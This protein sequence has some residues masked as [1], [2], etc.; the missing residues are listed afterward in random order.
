MYVHR[1]LLDYS[2]SYELRYDERYDYGDDYISYPRER[3]G[4]LCFFCGFRCSFNDV[5]CRCVGMDDAPSP[6]A[7]LRVIAAAALL[8]FACFS[9]AAA[10]VSFLVLLLFRFQTFRFPFIS[11]SFF[12]FMLLRMGLKCPIPVPDLYPRYLYRETCCG[13]LLLPVS[14]AAL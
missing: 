14:S 4:A 5:R 6:V 8:R 2:R 9:A 3:L 13:I 12:I 10:N 7:C 1:V 11:I